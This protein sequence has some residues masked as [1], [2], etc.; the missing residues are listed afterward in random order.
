MVVLFSSSSRYHN[1][2]HSE[3]ANFHCDYPNPV[4]LLLA[5]PLE[6]HEVSWKCLDF[7]A[8]GFPKALLKYFHQPNSP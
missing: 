6:V 2:G 5:A 7:P 4:P 8:L 1:L 3:I